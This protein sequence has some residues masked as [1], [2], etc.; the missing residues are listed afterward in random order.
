MNNYARK[1]TEIPSGNNN[2]YYF[3]VPL[4]HQNKKKV[5]VC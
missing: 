4:Q 3:S 1:K 2:L 5:L